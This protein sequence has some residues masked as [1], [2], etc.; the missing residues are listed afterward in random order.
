MARHSSTSGKP[1]ISTPGILVRAVASGNIGITT[2][3]V[4]L[5]GPNK[6][7]ITVMWRGMGYEVSAWPEGLRRVEEGEVL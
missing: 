5:S 7:R 6:G 2:E 1:D 4:K 3:R